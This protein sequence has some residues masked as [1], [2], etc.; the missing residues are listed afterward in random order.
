MVTH[1]QD[2]CNIMI[3]NSGSVP[4]T[5]EGTCILFGVGCT[6]VLHV[7]PGHVQAFTVVKL[8]MPNYQLFRGSTYDSYLYLPTVQVYITYLVH[9]LHTYIINTWGR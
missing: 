2:T 7:Q 8:D 9:V 5:E 6:W 1:T 3:N 4:N